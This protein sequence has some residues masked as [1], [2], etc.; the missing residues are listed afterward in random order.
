MLLLMASLAALLPQSTDT[1]VTVRPGS[2]L[3]LSSQE[4]DITVAT[5]S[6]NAIRIVADNDDDTRIDVDQ[7]G[8][9]VSLRAHHRYGPSGVTWKLTVPTDMALELSSQS[10]DITVDGTRGEV[11]VST[12]EGKVSVRGGTGFVTLQSVEGDIDLRDASGRI[13]LTTVDGSVK[14][15]GVRGDLKASAV[16]GEIL[17]DDVESSN[18]DASTVDGEIRFSG[19]IR[20]GGRYRLT[21]HDG[22]VTVTA[23]VIN[24]SVSVSTFSGD[25]DSD[26]PVTLSGS[27]ARKHMSFTLGSGGA[28]LELESFDGTVALRKGTGPR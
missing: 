17:L 4:G 20:D 16:D 10:G 1:T 19:A 26:F 6:R 14:A 28:R 7:S 8:G 18:V 11:N 2:R 24:A 21:S 22:D 5:W 15:G 13:S 3:E 23:P 12:V 25:F 9:I 27:S